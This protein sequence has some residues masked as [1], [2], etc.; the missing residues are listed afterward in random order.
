[1]TPVVIQLFYPI[2]CIADSPKINATVIP[3]SSFST[4]NKT[5]SIVLQ[6]KVDEKRLVL[7]DNLLYIYK[8]AYF[9]DFCVC[10]VI[11]QI[12]LLYIK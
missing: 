5:C 3:V 8:G 9:S 10:Y 4:Y 1:M 7:I 2:K 12:F 6:G 11:N